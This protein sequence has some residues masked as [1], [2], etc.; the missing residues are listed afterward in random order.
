VAVDP[1][2]QHHHKHCMGFESHLLS[3]HSCLQSVLSR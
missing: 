1:S 2:G 3:D